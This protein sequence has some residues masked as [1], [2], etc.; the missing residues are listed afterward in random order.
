MPEISS[1]TPEGLPSRCAVCG[2]ANNI[3]Y[4]DTGDDAPCPNC[5]CLLWRS[6]ARFVQLQNRIATTLG[7]EPALVAANERWDD[8]GADSLDRVELVMELE[9]EFGL[10]IADEDAANISTVADLV[11]YLES[12]DR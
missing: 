4:S 2:A 1:R 11:R 12:V 6:A 8:L 7:V 9:E 3:E 10:K 5:G